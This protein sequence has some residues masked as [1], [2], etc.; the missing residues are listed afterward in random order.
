MTANAKPNSDATD[1]EE[2]A[3]PIEIAIVGELTEREA[4]ICDKLLEV[5]PGGE[6]VLYFNSPG[7]SSYAALSLMSIIQLRQLNATGVVIGE[8]SSAALWPFAACKRRLV[9][10]YS[11]L[12]FHP[13]KWESE[14][15]VGIA[16]AAEWARHFAHLESTMDHLL[17]KLLGLPNVLVDGWV[18][19]GKH[20]TGPELVA[21]GAAEL[22]LPGDS[23]DLAAMATS[24]PP[25]TASKSSPKKEKLASKTKR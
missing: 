9:L 21:A 2:A 4:E 7:G 8:C 14:E 20:I 10:P 16:E 5:P 3:G 1:S 22:I 12:L 18:R 11:I 25:V 19:P 23:L 6:C 17:A 13:M 24:S 15:H